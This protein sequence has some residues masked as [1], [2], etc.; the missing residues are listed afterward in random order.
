MAFNFIEKHID[1]IPYKLLSQEYQPQSFDD[2]TGNKIVIETL[3]SFIKND[4]IP[5]LIL[6]GPNGCGKSTIAKIFVKQ[7]LGK[8]LKTCYMEIIGSICR[9]KTIVTEKNDKKK[10][11]DKSSD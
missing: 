7:Y 3:K 11:A 1:P 5:D 8:Y 6:N 2:F 10:T 4:K 9:G